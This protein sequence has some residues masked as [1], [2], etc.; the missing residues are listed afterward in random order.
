MKTRKMISK[1]ALTTI[2]VCFAVMTIATVLLPLTPPSS[3]PWPLSQPQCPR[4][5]SPPFR[6]TVL[7]ALQGQAPKHP[8]GLHFLTQAVH[9]AANG[10][11]GLTQTTLTPAPEAGTLRSMQYFVRLATSSAISPRTSSAVQRR[12]QTGPWKL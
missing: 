6:L 11:S 5:W 12:S 4:A 7:P 8:H 9:L 10:Q 3:L 1:C 2:Y